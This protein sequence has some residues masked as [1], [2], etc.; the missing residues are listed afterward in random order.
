[1][2]AT[3]REKTG[4]EWASRVAR[5][6]WW[7]RTWGVA[8]TREEVREGREGRLGWEASASVELDGG[9]EWP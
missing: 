3:N 6:E 1:M 2:P 5:R 8:G 9:E 7:A 4:E